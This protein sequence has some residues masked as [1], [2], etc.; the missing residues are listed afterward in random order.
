MGNM[1][2]EHIASNFFLCL[3]VVATLVVGLIFFPYLNALTIAIVFA[4]IFDPVYRKLRSFMPKYEGLASFITVL[5]TII[6][7]LIP[8]IF[9]GVTVFREA[10]SVYA[11]S[12]SGG[13]SQITNI[14]RDQV[15]KFFPSVNIDFSQ[16]ANGFLNW[17]I[18]NIGPIFSQV[19]GI[20]LII[21]LSAFALFY[22]L[23][24]GRKIHDS[25]VRISPLK[26]D[27]TE[28]ILDKLSKMVGSVI[29]GSLVV[30]T[31]QGLSIGLGFYLFGL[32][33]PVL[34]GSVAIICSFVPVIG[35]A[36]IVVPTAIIVWLSGNLS[37]AVAFAIWGLLLPGVIDNFLRPKLIDRDTHVSPLLVLFS[38]IGGISVFGPIGLVLGPL[39]LSLLLALFEIYPSI[40]KEDVNRA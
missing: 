18:A 38:V 31:L 23:K 13:N 6:I 8:L 24:D 26:H 29:K 37:I 36:L 10:Q 14:I 21:F 11:S 7:I 39:A 1:N 28:K 20:T 5:L 27:D 40:F 32:H 33:N 2:S 35:P 30:C 22:F 15:A 4:V 19:A 16:Y 25:V 17:L 9:F 12:I 34:W 3:L